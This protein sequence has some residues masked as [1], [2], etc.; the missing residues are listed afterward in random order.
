MV[1][2]SLHCRETAVTVR[3]S[4][5]WCLTRP[6]WPPWQG[7]IAAALSHAAELGGQQEPCLSP[8]VVDQGKE[9]AEYIKVRSK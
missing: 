4:L 2:L 9:S 6:T 3:G 5:W 8:V 7:A 1:M